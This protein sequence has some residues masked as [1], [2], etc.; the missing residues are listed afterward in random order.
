[1]AASARGRGDRVRHEERQ[2]DGAEAEPP[3]EVE[4]ASRPVPGPDR[5]EEE[6]QAVAEVPE[7]HVEGVAVQEREDGQ[8]EPLPARCSRQRGAKGEREQQEISGQDQLLAHAG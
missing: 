8:R 7:P 6:R 4:A 5:H 3:A 2:H 1:M